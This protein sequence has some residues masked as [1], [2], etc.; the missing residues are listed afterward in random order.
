[1]VLDKVWVG[2]VTHNAAVSTCE[3]GGGWVKVLGSLS[4]MVLVGVRMG[5]I[6]QNPAISACEKG[7]ELL[8]GLGLLMPMMQDI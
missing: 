2:A 1:M 4:A 5:V 3:K 8:M 7:G 6:T